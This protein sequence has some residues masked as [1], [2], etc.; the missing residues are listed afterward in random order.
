VSLLELRD[1]YARHG[2]AAG[3]Q[4]AALRGVTLT[5]ESGEF[6]A[7]LGKSGAGK[8]T[9]LRSIARSTRVSG[10]VRFEDEVVTRHSPA[11]MCRLGVAH[12]PQGGGVFAP[13]S[14]LDNLRL[15]AWTVRG[16]LDNAY[17]RVFELFPFLYDLR[18]ADAGTLSPGEQRLLALGSA[19]MGKPRLLLCDE[20]S[21][22]VPRDI[23]DEFFAA[24]RELHDR[25]TT[26]VVTAQRKGRALASAGHAIV[27][28]DGRVV[29]DGP[30]A[31]VAVATAADATSIAS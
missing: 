4:S 24:L 26:I 14:V 17:V 25:G 29:F 19:V 16:P 9:L 12:A 27:L 10:E 21:A 6:V 28:E 15:G 23:G 5:I 22:G 2:N 13:L 3:L 20:P 11:A 1:V 8:T 31:E 18:H 30:A 7:V